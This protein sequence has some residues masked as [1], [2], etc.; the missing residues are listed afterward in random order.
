M[1]EIEHLKDLL[2]NSVS[3]LHG[4]IVNL[5]EFHYCKAKK[6]GHPTIEESDVVIIKEVNVH[7]GKWRL[8]R[9]D[10]LLKGTDGEIRS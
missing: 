6:A 7:H 8:A 10:K 9:V 3:W 5:R 1:A 2:V 4:Y